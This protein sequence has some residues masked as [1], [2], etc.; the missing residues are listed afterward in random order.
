VVS[1]QRFPVSVIKSA[2][3]RLDTHQLALLSRNRKGFV[4][5]EQDV[6]VA[7]SVVCP[8]RYVHDKNRILS[9]IGVSAK[10]SLTTCILVRN[11]WRCSMK[12]PNENGTSITPGIFRCRRSQEG[13]LYGACV[14][15]HS[16]AESAK[17]CRQM[18][19]YHAQ[20]Y[21]QQKGWIY[22]CHFI[23]KAPTQRHA[24]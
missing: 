7:T 14:T 24:G 15:G 22:F 10:G 17:F 9:F 5:L 3:V 20:F 16:A 1:C 6:S 4:G 11:S 18:C 8:A 23:S 12:R 13:L 21:H 2:F 19:P